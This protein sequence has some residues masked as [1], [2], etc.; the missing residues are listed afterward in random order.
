MV[1]E[2]I[3]Y[4]YQRVVYAAIQETERPLPLHCR[5]SGWESW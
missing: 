1:S 5:S 4:Q 2:E 3:A